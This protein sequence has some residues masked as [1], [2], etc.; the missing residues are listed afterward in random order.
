MSGCVNGEG[1]VAAQ[2]M[3]CFEALS[4]RWH[5]AAEVFYRMKADRGEDM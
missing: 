3:V 1:G 2:G 5:T 4:L